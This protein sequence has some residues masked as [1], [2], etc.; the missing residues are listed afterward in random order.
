MVDLA[1]DKSESPKRLTEELSSLFIACIAFT[2][3]LKVVPVQI[4]DILKRFFTIN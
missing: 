1:I 4:I 2:H 3:L